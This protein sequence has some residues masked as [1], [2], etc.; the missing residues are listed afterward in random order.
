MPAAA[1]AK[2]VMA[3]AKRL[4]ELRHDWRNSNRMAEIKVPA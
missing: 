1:T 3:S 4:I 2:R